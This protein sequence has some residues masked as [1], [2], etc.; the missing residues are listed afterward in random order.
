MR[1][2]IERDDGVMGVGVD[3]MRTRLTANDVACGIGDACFDWWSESSSGIHWGSSCLPETPL[4]TV[5]VTPPRTL[6]VRGKGDCQS[7]FRTE[8][9]A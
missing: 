8:R 9:N 4:P 1:G 3:R 2:V 7:R 6:P 5:S